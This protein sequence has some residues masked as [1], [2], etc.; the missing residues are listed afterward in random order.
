MLSNVL[1][2]VRLSG[3]AFLT[4]EFS[5]PWSI[6]SVPPRQL[7]ALL[8]PTCKH[9]GIFHILA[10][11][12]CWIE[13]E[14]HQPLQMEAG[15]VI[16]FPQGDEH[17][18]SSHLGI[19]PTPVIGIFPRPPYKEMPRLAFGGGGEVTRFICGYL[20]YD[21]EFNP[22]F[23]A[24]PRLI[25]VRSRNGSIAL[26][27]AG[28]QEAPSA[29][30]SPPASTWLETNLRYLIAEATLSRKGNAALLTRLTEVLFLEIV[31]QYIEQLPASQKGWFAGLNDA[32]VGKALALLHQE[33]AKPW[34]VEALARSAGI[35]RSGLAD[36]FNL[37]LG[38]SPMRYLTAWRM[39]LAQQFLRRQNLSI[40]E[41]ALRVGYTSEF[42]FSRAFKRHVGTPP[43]T[44]RRLQ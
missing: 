4:A 19:E 31:R 40:A 43:A 6:R 21:Q 15:E 29:P 34:T 7:A 41:V 5:S 37:L 20:H 14:G 2:A 16:V 23:R 25:L 35:S 3:A 1:H 27:P 8:M 28:N 12:Q 33:P 32:H 44:W 24:L 22:L 9:C 42:T 30:M 11:G 36:R 38:E 26:E 39:L 17:V 18:M 13:P 10:E